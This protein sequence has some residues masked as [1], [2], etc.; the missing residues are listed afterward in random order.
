MI[1]ILTGLMFFYNLIN[2]F[3]RRYIKWFPYLFLLLMWILF[4]GNYQN[5]DYDN[6]SRSYLYVETGSDF[7]YFFIKN[8]F[9]SL[10]LNYHIFLSIFTLIGML[11]INCTVRRFAENTSYIYALYFIYPFLLDVVQLR[12]FMAMAIFIFAIP[13]LL[14]QKK[15]D[16]IK[17]IILILLASTFQ[18]TAIV[19]LPIIFVNKFKTNKLIR[20]MF[21]F[22]VL[23]IIILSFN[24]TFLIWTSNIIIR[25]SNDPRL[26]S[27]LQIKTD[28]GFLLYW[29]IQISNFLLVLWSKRILEEKNVSFENIENQKK[30][31]YISSEFGNLVTNEKQ[32]KFV[33][34]VYWINIYAFIF[35]PFYVFQNTFSRFMR[36]ITLLNLIV[37]YIS[38]KSLDKN[39]NKKILYN[40]FIFGYSLFLFYIEIYWAYSETIV[41]AIFKY[42]IFF[43]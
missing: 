13:F 21:V 31:S 26:T 34:L 5:P 16:Y 40:L 18:M 7:G 24:H 25:I 17:Y 37:F 39:S 1:Y 43:K 33:N 35:L 6:Y 20:K 10:G 42:N 19:Y 14:S 4:F 9:L 15:T 11:L 38:N 23:L 22:L 41:G 29:C 8:I 2:S 36:N 12:N 28:Y 3:T 32:K 27:W 30:S